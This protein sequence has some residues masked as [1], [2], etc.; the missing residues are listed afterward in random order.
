MRPNVYL[1]VVDSLRPDHVGCLTETG[2]NT[3][4]LDRL[5]QDSV[6]FARA[7]SQATWSKPAASA[8]LTGLYPASTE[9]V[10]RRR[11]LP[12]NVPTMAKML[13]ANGYE[14][15]GL[16]ANGF[17]IPHFGFGGGFD[18]FPTLQEDPRFRTRVRIVPVGPDAH[19]SKS[20]PII[21][22]ADLN[23]LL[24]EW[25]A[26]RARTGSPGFAM[27]WS[28]DT[29]GPYFDRNA[30]NQGGEIEHLH[31]PHMASVERQR[32]IELYRS[33]VRFADQCIGGFVEGLRSAGVYDDAL[34]IVCSDH[35]EALGEHGLFG[36]AGYPFDELVHV[37]LWI[38]FP[39]NRYGGRICTALVE[40]IDVLPTVLKSLGVSPDW[41][42][43]GHSLIPA[44]RGRPWGGRRWVYA[45]GQA[46]ERENR[47]AMVRGGSW[48][49][50][51]MHDPSQP[52]MPGD[53]FF[54]LAVDPS[55]QQDLAQPKV[56]F[57][58]K[59]RNPRLRYASWAA[60]K[61]QVDNRR[62]FERYVGVAEDAEPE[63]SV[64]GRLQA[65]GYIE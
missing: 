21:T 22:G 64:E 65:L 33:M 14:T 44:I 59:S 2:R 49:Y 9:T 24:W 51:V 63:E 61:R 6:L 19:P 39:G 12:G 15:L 8:I 3:P 43:Q 26:E 48:K 47:Y 45:S 53:W 54:D 38:K 55:E 27:L 30:L 58:D 36:H 25:R 4:H 57:P 37:P 52:Q 40:L 20:Q 1:Y 56:V 32:V 41:P 35:G 5:C 7:F 29:H 23:T 16:S 62:Y 46:S 28:M 34:V 50:I 60:R 18:E 17:V 31:Y 10:F 13:S 11:R 42:L